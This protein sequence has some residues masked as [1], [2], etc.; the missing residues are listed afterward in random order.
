MKENR[1]TFMA[2]REKFHAARTAD[3][4]KAYADAAVAETD[5]GLSPRGPVLVAVANE[6]KAAGFADDAGRVK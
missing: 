6:L 5:F 2:A 3:T 4:A 1:T